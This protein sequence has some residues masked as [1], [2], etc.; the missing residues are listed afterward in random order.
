MSIAD[1]RREYSLTGLRKAD[2]AADP[3]QQFR[4]WFDQAL[5]AGTNE[6]NAMVLA[7]ADAAGKPSTRVVLLKGLDERG[8]VFFTNYESRKA[9]EL[10]VNHYAAL[11]FFW[12]EL[13]RQVCVT[14]SVTQVPREEAEAYF[15]TRPRGSRLGAWASKQSVTVPSRE[16]LEARLQE[17]EKKYPGEEI[18]LPPF[19]GGY[20]LTPREIDFWQGRPNRLHDRF[21][22]SKQSD[23]RWLVER[24]SP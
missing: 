13:E 4:H 23:G 16:V 5:A 7:T 14:G 21:R 11:N 2:L 24:L 15:K 17:L 1:L 3:L 8:F 10:A 6:P 22:Y 18:P 9:R 20:V 19:W 12:V